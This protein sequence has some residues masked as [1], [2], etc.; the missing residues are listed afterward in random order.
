M[1]SPDLS[2]NDLYLLAVNL[3]RRCNLACAHCYMDA[4]T[5]KQGGADELKTAE[6]NALLEQIASRGT[7]TMVVLTGGEPLLRRDLE[8]MV[9]HGSELGLSMVIG[10]N[11][12]AL[13]DRRVKSLQAAGVMGMGISLDSLDPVRH[14]EFR[15]YPGGWE[16]TLAGMEACRRNGLPFQVHFSVTEENA[17]EIR[18]MIDFAATVG[19]HVLNVFFLICTGRGE[20]MSDI[21][22]LRYER[23]LEELVDAQTST[24]LIVR[25]R[26]APHFKRVAYQRDPASRLTRADGY[27]GGGCLA[28]IHY[29]RVTPEG[30]ITACPYIPDEEDNIRQAPFW[31][32]WDHSPTFSRLRNPELDGKCGV[33][34][35]RLLCGGCRA[36]PKA[37]GGTL[38]DTDPWCV[39]EPGDAELI[40]PL[41][42]ESSD[43]VTW[44]AEAEQRLSR[45]PGFL[46]KMV[47]KRAQ[48]FV[49]ESGETVVSVEHMATLAARRFGE[50]GPPST[51]ESPRSGALAWTSEAQKYLAGVPG[52]MRDGIQEVAESVAREE[53][54][55][56][57]NMKLIRRLEGEALWQR[58]R[59]WEPDA[60]Q[61]LVTM[62]DSY[63]ATMRTFVQPTME[64]AAEREAKRRS[65]TATVSVD[66]VRTVF[67]TH[68][69]AVEWE[70]EVLRRVESAP[71]FVR[72]GIKKAAEFNARREGIS[73]ITDDDLTRFRNR[74]MMRAVR[75]MKGF[76]M[77]EL[78]FSA[79]EIARER[80]PRLKDNVQAAKR[81]AAIQDYV[82]SHKDAD[83]GGLGLMDRDLIEQMKAELKRGKRKT[84]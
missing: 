56:E 46:R 15:G 54:R 19:A 35:F 38:M 7:D 23:V 76:G 17:D 2:A 72:A 50:D 14:D 59:S 52:F 32:I 21:S 64:A 29:C 66:D 42:T 81:F 37:L 4:E 44:S 49:R 34:E 40:Q 55:L 71:E 45:V 78:D 31:E 61:E 84:K 10:T 63:S 65:K 30:G 27:E 82:E 28:G 74:A 73:T 67:T 24:D 68:T 9:A 39:Y 16:K 18:A 20:S 51:Q 57:V 60:E 83:G 3:T 11:G 69:A 41:A 70:P 8:E 36:R 6:V 43:D 58:N 13:T 53:G 48:D 1:T 26:C 5:L 79:F 33:C 25:A 62:L 47:R 75:R 22:P 77:R 12:V 80:V